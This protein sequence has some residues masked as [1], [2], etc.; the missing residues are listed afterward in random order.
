MKEAVTRDHILHDCLHELSRK[1]KSIETKN[2]LIVE[3]GVNGP[4]GLD[5]G[6]LLEMMKTF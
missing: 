6:S 3:I 4:D 1:W 5:T 2:R